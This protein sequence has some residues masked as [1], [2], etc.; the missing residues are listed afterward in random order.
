MARTPSTM[1][2]LGTRRAFDLPNYNTGTGEERVSVRD[3]AG[4]RGCWSCSSATTALRH[5]RRRRTR[6]PRARRQGSRHRGCRHQRQRHPQ[7]P[8]DAPVHM[9]GSRETGL[10]FPYLFDETR[11]VA[12]ATKPPARPTS[13]SSMPTSTSPTGASSTTPVGLRRAH[14]GKDLRRAIN[15]VVAGE[16]VGTDQKPS[17]GCNIK[18][19][20]GNEPDYFG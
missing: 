2:E 7:T 6:P 19:K 8:A 5:P 15:A 1:L 14:H 4:P 9:T 20:P 17:M 11:E 10:H 16:D 3:A 12:K 18:W 13:S